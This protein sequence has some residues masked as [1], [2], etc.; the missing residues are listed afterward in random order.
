MLA[1][2]IMFITALATAGCSAADDAVSVG[3]GSARPTPSASAAP[4]VPNE[5]LEA[6]V[7]TTADLP[8]GGWVE[9]ADTSSGGG[10]T[11]SKDADGPGACAADFSQQ[12]PDEEVSDATNAGRE[13]TR[14]AT[15]SYLSALV[16]Q[17]PD[18]EE[19]VR[20][21]ADAVRGC[22][23]AGSTYTID[24]QE[25]RITTTLVDLGAWGDATACIRFEGGGSGSVAGR[26][27]MIADDGYLVGVVTGSQFTFQLPKDDE[28]RQIVDA[29]VTKAHEQLH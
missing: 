7:L 25:Q 1:T 22:P 11:T 13:W 19:R 24:G 5:A 12:I 10:G 27:C 3:S 16:A 15:S 29:A 4:Q 23:T 17:V 21:I 26:L 18:A 14:E 9:K 8:V 6:A 20:S 28:V 2:S